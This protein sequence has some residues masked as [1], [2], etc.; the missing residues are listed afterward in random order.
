MQW[1]SLRIFVS[2]KR[3][4]NINEL[5]A[6]PFEKRTINKSNARIKE[7]LSWNNPHL[8]RIP[9]CHYLQSNSLEITDIWITKVHRLNKTKKD[10]TNF[11][12]KEMTNFRIFMG[13]KKNHSY[14]HNW[15][16]RKT[17]ACREKQRYWI[18][19]KDWGK[20][21]LYKRIW[22][23]IWIFYS[24][25][26][27]FQ[28]V[29]ACSWQDLDSHSKIQEEKKDTNTKLIILGPKYFL[30]FLKG[31]Y[32]LSIVLNVKG[33]WKLLT[34]STSITILRFRDNHVTNLISQP[35]FNNKR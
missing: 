24:F 26:A 18:K 21:V 27:I 8:F 23:G 28:W 35:I 1:F 6:D 16:T 12:S 3:K 34:F 13:V 31:M 14:L 25:F 7:I 17:E 30:I 5:K 2:K 15:E 29:T 22:N 32:D 33:T 19:S 9:R 10:K 4:N 11:H 20:K